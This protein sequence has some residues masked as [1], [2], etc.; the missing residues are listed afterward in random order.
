M[1]EFDPPTYSC[2]GSNDGIAS[3][4]IMQYR[5]QELSALGIPTEF[6][7]YEGLG[8]G[9]GIGT[10]SVADGWINDAIDF[11]KKNMKQESSSGIPP[12]YAD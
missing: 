2:V 7:V 11:W 1:S 6:H 10:G 5:L 9:F 3:W 12:I 8:H 4:R